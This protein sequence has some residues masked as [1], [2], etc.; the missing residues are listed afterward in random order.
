MDQNLIILCVFLTSVFFG[1][2]L[3]NE[4]ILEGKVARLLA[5]FVWQRKI[6]LRSFWLFQG[7]FWQH[8]RVALQM[9]T[10]NTSTEAVK[11]PVE[12]QGL[13]LLLGV[14]DLSTR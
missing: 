8:T 2:T 6:A 10:A 1:S 5:Q 13:D 11:G 14:A 3:V 9:G 7:F 12:E 4:S